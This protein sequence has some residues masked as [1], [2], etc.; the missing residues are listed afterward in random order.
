[1]MHATNP[2]LIALC[3]RRARARAV[4]T[5]KV[6][7]V[8]SEV[9]GEGSVRDV[10]SAAPK[11]RGVRAARACGRVRRKWPALGGNAGAVQRPSVHNDGNDDGDND[12]HD[13]D[14]N[15]HDDSIRHDHR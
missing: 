13:D 14:G 8:C 1:M 12:H 6:A 3:P 15:H 4:P 9:P 11:R 10:D 5:P 2:A 7:R